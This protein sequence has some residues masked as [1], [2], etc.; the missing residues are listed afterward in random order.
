MN[1]GPAATD[2]LYRLPEMLVAAT[3]SLALAA[4]T[5]VTLGIHRPWTTLPLA[6]V[7]GIVLWRAIRPADAPSDADSRA[8]KWSLGGVA[9]WIVV[10]IYFASEYL[11]VTRDP[12]FLALTG[13][14]LTDHPTT[15]IPTRG[16]IEAARSATQRHRR[17]MASLESVRK[18]RSAA[19]REDASGR[20][21]GRRLG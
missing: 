15:D 7:V 4:G 3:V 21:L 8:A 14:W 19:R 10:G 2:L 18:R 20:P 11:V 6:L 5:T 9:A 16:A 1:A 17:R 12:G 13:V